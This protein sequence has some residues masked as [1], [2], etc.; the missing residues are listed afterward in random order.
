[1]PNGFPTRL[2]GKRI[3]G[4]EIPSEQRPSSFFSIEFIL[5]FQC[6]PLIWFQGTVYPMSIPTSGIDILSFSWGVG[7]VV[8]AARGVRAATNP[9]QCN[10]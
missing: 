8:N 10:I 2:L 1:M 7:S 3:Y 4:I 5:A 6:H 9:G